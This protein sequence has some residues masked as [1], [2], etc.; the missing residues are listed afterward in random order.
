MKWKLALAQHPMYLLIREDTQCAERTPPWGAPTIEA[1]IQRVDQNLDALDRYPQ[2]KLGYEWSGVE[3]ELLAI[4]SPEVFEKL[5]RYADQGRVC[6]YNGTYA[7]PHLQT[8]SA[9]SNLRQFEFGR[10][11]YEELS[12]NPV[13]VYAHQEASVH[14]QVPQLLHAFGIPIA[15]VPGFLTTLS[16]LDENEMLLHGVRGP[17]FIQGSEFAAWQGLDGIQVS[18]YLHQPIPRET[19]LRETLAREVVLGRLSAPPLMIDLPD[20]I[21]IDDDW[22]EERKA[23]EFVTLDQALRERLRE[24][25]AASRARLYTNWSYLEGIRAEELSRCNLLAEREALRAE[26]INGLAWA[27]GLSEPVSTDGIWKTI[28]KSQHHDAYCFSAPELRLKSIGW[29]GKAARQAARLTSDS[30]ANLISHIQTDR[31]LGQPVVVFSTNPHSQT[32]MIETTTHLANQQVFDELGIPVFCENR[33]ASEAGTRVRFTARTE[34]LGY[35]TYWLRGGYNSSTTHQVSTPFTFENFYY[36]A[37]LQPDGSFTSLKLLPGAVELINSTRGAGNTLTATDSAAISFQAETMETRFDYYL[38]DPE[39][40]GPRLAWTAT[41]PAEVTQSQLGATVEVAGKMSEQIHARLTVRFYHQLPRIEINYAFQF[42]RASVGTF[43]D[44]DSKLL[45]SWPLALDGK[46]YHDIPFG[47]IQEREDRTFFPVSWSDYTDGENG[48]TFF[49]Q[50]T[51]NHWVHQR[52][53]VNLLGWGED[54]DAI[55]NGL[56]RSQWVKSFDQR[57]D[58]EHTI[59]LAVLP[60]AGD[61][62]TAGLPQAAL[63]YGIPPVA[64]QSDSH[65][66]DLPSSLALLQLTDP[67]CVATSIRVNAGHLVCRLFST[68]KERIIPQTLTHE[69][70]SAGLR[71]IQGKPVAGLNPYQ[72][73][74]LLY[75]R[76]YRNYST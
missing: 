47:V 69:I 8:L 63:E 73:G 57:L 76:K 13:Q 6:F 14:D 24:H 16:W 9:E 71:L 25:P 11:V 54:T 52:T 61:W 75:T 1:Y 33:P 58:G 68:G 37:V 65:P 67:D 64:I 30:A 32:G 18:L 26:A 7:Q 22:I 72:I 15:V 42:D 66:G 12:L 55:H 34:G 19:T 56:G 36:R 50:G 31:A 17:R 60:H 35:T 51:P 45:V 43:F 5:R 23:V 46:I 40:R 74:E 48:V 62:R 2:L 3:L 39:Y 27:L 10:K 70:Q 59:N 29:L 44:D 21:A 38:A 49:H 20:M 53:L 28:L 41:A 4:D